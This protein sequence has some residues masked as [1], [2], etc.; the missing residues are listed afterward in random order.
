MAYVCMWFCF[1]IPNFALIGQYGADMAEERFSKCHLG[2]GNFYFFVTSPFLKS[3]IA[4]VYQI[5]LKSNNSQLTYWGKPFS[6][7]RSSAFFNFLNLLIKR[8]CFFTVNFALTMRAWEN[9]N[10]EMNREIKKSPNVIF[11]PFAQKSPLNG[12]SPN[13]ACGVVPWT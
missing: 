3:K 12:L 11:R 6:R 8:V 4:S 9:K 2:F 13:L 10:K 5:L 1:L 7:W